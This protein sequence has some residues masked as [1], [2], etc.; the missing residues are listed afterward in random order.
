MYIASARA[1]TRTR[2]GAVPKTVVALGVVSLLTD[3]SA[4]MI[5]AFLPVYLLFSLNIGYV[6]FG[7]LDG[8]Y[9]GATAVLRLVGGHFADRLRRPKLVAGVGYG[10]SALT[11]L[12][13]PAVGASALGIGGVIAADRAGKGLRTAP[14]DALI[15][16]SVPGDQLGTAFGV[17][18][19]MDTVGALIGPVVTFLILMNLG[20]AP[21]PIFVVSFG[22]AVLGLI[23]LGFFVP[24]R[25][26]A[27]ASPGPAPSIK[28]GLALLKD[29]PFRR[30]GV[31][32]A[33]L[34]VA[35][36]SDAFV[37]VL[38]QR[39]TEVPLGVLPLLPLGTALTFLLFAAPLGRLADVIGR[40]PVFFG[41]HV[42]LL[43]VYLLLLAPAGG[44]GVAIA[45]LLMHGL[46]YA[47][48][49]GVLSAW[50]GAMIPPS[51]RGSGLAVVQTGQALAR[52]VSSI[53]FGFLLQ[54][55]A[56]GTAVLTAVCALAAALVA[57]L[58]VTRKETTS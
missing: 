34:G 41:G 27:T 39:T 16:L 13:F 14:R 45:A 58:V 28:A 57:V 3:V 23:V 49:D 18:R 35:T 21:T 32:A 24:E 26:K 47:S 11:K 36:V 43:G 56:L 6:Q 15:S 48:T 38:V 29:V 22:F 9:T 53:G 10:L 1:G 33:L 40:W 4:E 30:A 51:L 37:F 20:T 42:L 2:L 12:V 5:T 50:T 7:L 54:Y 44:Y 52:L 31:V 25:P 19:S 55:A 46:F 17:H 8:L